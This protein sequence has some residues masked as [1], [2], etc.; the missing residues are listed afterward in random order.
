MSR[1]VLAILTLALAAAGIASAQRPPASDTAAV[2]AVGADSVVLHFVDADLRA[3]FQALG[4]Y[5]DRPLLLGALP[6][7]RI[8]LE[9]P[10]PVSR[11]ELLAYVRGLM[12]SQNLE[13][14]RDSAFY[15]VR[16][17][18][19]VAPMAPP[20]GA[21]ARAAG[22]EPELT[23]IRLR[24]A[25][26]TDVAATLSALYGAGGADLGGARPGTLSEEL[27]RNQVPP[28]GTPPATAA[29][30]APNAR[31]AVL[32]GD[33]TIVPDPFTNALLVRAT[34]RDAELLR[35]AAQELDLRPLQV[36]IE[37]LIVETRK[38]YLLSWGLALSL[39]PT[40]VGH[41]NTTIQGTQQGGGL[42]D[43]VLRLLNVGGV[44]LNAQLNA[45]A[46]RGDVR[47]LSRPVLLA[48]NNHDARIL[49][50]SQRPFVQVS[51]T[52]PTDNGVRDQVVQYKDVGTRLSVRPTIS[53]DGAYVTLDVVQEVSNATNETQF[54]APVIATREAVTQV[55]VRDGQT[56]VLGGLIDHQR[57]ATNGGVPFLS[58]LPLIGGLFGRQSRRTSETELFLFITP[59]VLHTD[60]DIQGATERFQGERRC[61]SARRG[62]R[63]PQRVG[64][65]TS[66]RVLPIST[67]RAY[68]RVGPAS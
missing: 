50:G 17:R 8:T 16:Q 11:S 2:R 62:P 64:R 25:R 30:A 60:D 6:P 41:G 13:L 66:C 47:I 9:T 48:A 10:R 3:V 23:V 35:A 56:I 36:L 24:H 29:D 20:P 27:R 67:R 37:V 54:D 49:V 32:E 26:A 55:T 31:S 4:R 53:A 40:A 63:I 65:P 34:R 33:V 51:R 7:A 46:S 12:D 58:D 21:A 22:G 15:R 38:D 19:P 5:L 28:V 52:L 57:D 18:E 43:L 61:G 45:G 39:P 59:R 1:R 42:G 14:V 68:R 44:D